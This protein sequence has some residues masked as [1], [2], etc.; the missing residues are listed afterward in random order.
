MRARA[1]AATLTA[2][3][4]KLVALAIAGVVALVV[5][6]LVLAITGRL[7][8]RLDRQVAKYRTTAVMTSSTQWHTVR[9]LSATIC[10]KNEVSATVGV[11]VRGGPVAVRVLQDGGPVMKPGPAR[12]VPRGSES[13]S[14]TFV[15]PTGTFE[16]NDH[17][18]F[19]VQWRSPRGVPVRLRRGDL[20]L[21]FERGTQC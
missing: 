19:E 13:F 1:L 6:V 12:F 5:P 21:L 11:R 8:S 7:A 16:A 9:G 17:H 14:F 3:R 4:K 2:V 20:N 18:S 15:N 10:S